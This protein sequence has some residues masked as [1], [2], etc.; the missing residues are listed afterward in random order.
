[1]LTTM[2]IVDADH[3]IE[4]TFTLGS[5]NDIWEKK[6]KKNSNAILFVSF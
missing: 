1:M 6:R 5:G 3:F 4:K 2:M